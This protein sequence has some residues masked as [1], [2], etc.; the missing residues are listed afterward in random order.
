MNCPGSPAL[1]EGLPETSSSYAVEGTAAHTL[2]KQCRDMGQPA[3]DFEDTLIA[4]QLENG[5]TEHVHVDATMTAAVQAFLDEG[6]RQAAQDPR[7]VRLYE[8]QFNLAALNPPEEMF[9]T[10]DEVNYL[11]K[12]RRLHVNDLKYGQGIIVEAVDNQQLL[13]YAIGALLKF[14]SEYGYGLIDDLV[15]TIV[16]PRI[17]H[18]EGIVRSW[19][20]SYDDVL[21]FAVTLME[22]ARA[23]QD[24]KAPRV[25]GSWCRFCKAAAIC[26]ERRAGA[27]AV[28]LVEFADM[29]IQGPPDPRAL[30]VAQLADILTNAHLLE[31][32]LKAVRDTAFALL[33]RGETVPGW[34]LVPKKA[35]RAWVSEEAVLAWAEQQGIP[36]KNL[37]ETKLKSPA[38]IE[39]TVLKG[40]KK[41]LPEDLTHKPSS[42]YTIAPDSDPRPAALVGPAEF[43]VDPPP[44]LANPL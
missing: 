26:P 43:S 9:G 39:K 15:L 35:N 20:V 6:D 31:D 19:T 3:A 22:K 30:P 23:V 4:V 21:A 33:N 17:D 12:R 10:A 2:A 14:E 38:Q 7:A 44:Q 25:V 8:Y 36:P 18:S 24:P 40:T 16:Q 11:P 13:D 28:A 42:G 5:A 32:Y 27:E 29:P 41:A 34:K 37:H 1:S